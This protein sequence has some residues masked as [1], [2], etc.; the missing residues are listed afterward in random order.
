MRNEV[1]RLEGE[2]VRDVR[3]VGDLFENMTFVDCEF[4]DSAFLSVELRHCTF[5]NCRFVRCRI[6]TPKVY[7]T[8]LQNAE[9]DGCALSGIQFYEF[10][11]RTRYIA[12]FSAIRNTVIRYSAFS[13]MK[14]QRLDFS[15]NEIIESMFA[16]CGLSSANF[17]ETRL[18][19]TEFFRCDLTGADFRDAVGYKV[20]VLTCKVR[21]ARFALPEAIGLLGGLGIKLE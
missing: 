9:I 6:E 16:E 4:A 21:G 10:A 8:V 15:G 12:P 1:K 13:E 19:R 3:F 20:D 2:T 14:F 5:Q 11:T 18:D 17:R 7:E